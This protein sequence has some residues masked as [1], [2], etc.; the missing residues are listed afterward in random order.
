[1][2]NHLC[3]D[4]P[5][6]PVRVIFIA[7]SVHSGSTILDVVLGNHPELQGTG[8]LSNLHKVWQKN[9]YCSCGARVQACPFWS[10]VVQ[11]WR[12]RMNGDALANYGQL[13]VRYEKSRS[14]PIIAIAAL[15]GSHSFVR[16]RCYNFGLFSA[17]KDVSGKSILVDSSKRPIRALA[18]SFISGIDLR[19]IHLVRDGRGVAWSFSQ[20]R[21]KNDKLGVQRDTRPRNVIRVA[22]T[23][24]ITNL[25]TEYVCKWIG[26]DR[27]VRIR[28]EDLVAQPQQ[29]LELIGETI[30]MDLSGF[31]KLLDSRK[32]LDPGHIVAG[33]RLRMRDEIMLKNESDSWRFKLPPLKRRIFGLICAWVLTRYGYY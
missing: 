27:Y 24:A 4:N 8:E 20:S 7:G 17:I 22:V 2:S 23:W 33:N 26:T 11:M 18:L 15:F 1:M 30:S 31:G 5:R 3:R 16:Y 25:V 13:Q 28:Y 10:D 32:P 6:K 21:A 14:I 9:H 12:E 19:V 29:F